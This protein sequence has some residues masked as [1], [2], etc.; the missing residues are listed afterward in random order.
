MAGC[1]GG[2]PRGSRIVKAV[3]VAIQGTGNVTC[4]RS[5]RCTQS[6][7][8]CEQYK[9]QLLTGKPWGVLRT[10][11]S[12]LTKTMLP[13]PPWNTRRKR[14]T[15]SAICLRITRVTQS[16]SARQARSV[17]PIAVY[18]DGARD[19]RVGFGS[20]QPDDGTSVPGLCCTEA[21]FLQVWLQRL[22]HVISVACFLAVVSRSD[23]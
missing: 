11:K 14:P 20:Q 4:R 9:S 8:V 10:P 1:D 19:A 6:A 3:C 18:V 12:G 2:H 23:G 5:C 16:C 21:A 15:T 17:L 7:T 13:T 22:V